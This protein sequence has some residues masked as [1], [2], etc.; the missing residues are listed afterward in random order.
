[1]LLDGNGINDLKN[2]KPEK[3]NV[4]RQNTRYLYLHRLS[5]PTM[6]SHGCLVVAASRI[7]I[8]VLGILR[9]RQPSAGGVA[10]VAAHGA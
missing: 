3:I 7:G 5:R 8:G 10:E 2:S 4:K 9:R 1:M 6:K